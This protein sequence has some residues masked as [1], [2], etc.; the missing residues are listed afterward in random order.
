MRLLSHLVRRGMNHQPIHHPEV[1]NMRISYDSGEL[2]EQSVSKDPYS[3][4]ERWFADAK[5][6]PNE[7]N[8][9]NLSTCLNNR[10]SSRIVLLKDYDTTGFVFYTNYNSRKAQELD[11][12]PFAALTFYWPHETSSRSVR[13]EGEVERVSQ[14]E[15]EA[16]FATRPRGSQIGAWTSEKQ[17]GIIP[18]GRNELENREEKVK[19]SFNVVETVPKP[20]FWGGYRVKPDRF[21]FWQGRASRLHDRL[22]YIKSENGGW[23]LRRLSP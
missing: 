14:E 1:A 13:I 7:P 16:Y 6:D 8:A 9:M 15:S 10:P 22:E 19:E 20:P 3:Q 11:G 12:N 4:F 5:R 2:L 23:S 18:G 21:E 17:S